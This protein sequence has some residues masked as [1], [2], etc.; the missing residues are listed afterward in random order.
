MSIKNRNRKLLDQMVLGTSPLSVDG[1]GLSDRQFCR[2]LESMVRST[3]LFV[4]SSGYVLLDGLGLTYMF[5]VIVCS[6]GAALLCLTPP[7]IKTA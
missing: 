2:V 1:F 6:F 4:R 5:K 3:S 7:E